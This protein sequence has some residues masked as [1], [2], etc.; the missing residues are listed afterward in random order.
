MSTLT[1][2]ERN[3][4]QAMTEQLRYWRSWWRRLERTPVRDRPSHR[5]I[6]NE[7][8]LA[9]A[10][11]EHR[12]IEMDLS[13]WLDREPSASDKVYASQCYKSLEA[14]GYIVRLYVPGGTRTCAIRILPAGERAVA[15][16]RPAKPAVAPV[17]AADPTPPETGVAVENAAAVS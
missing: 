15:V 9:R 12:Q 16:K 17:A 2:F 10:A 6:A 1:T 11:V 3:L 7:T 5:S 4:L 14:K 13:F 8:A